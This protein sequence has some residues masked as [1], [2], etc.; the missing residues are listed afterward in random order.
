MESVLMGHPEREIPFC[1]KRYRV[2]DAAGQVIF[3]SEQ[4]HQ[5]RVS[6]RFAPAVLTAALSVEILETWGAPAAIFEA[7]CFEE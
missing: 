1:V 7:R 4:N 6:V 5:T 2:R 3:E